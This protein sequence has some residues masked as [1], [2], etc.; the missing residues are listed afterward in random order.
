M[1]N[2]FSLTKSNLFWFLSL[3][4]IQIRNPFLKLYLFKF[5]ALLGLHCCAGFSLVVAL[6][7]G[8]CTSHCSGF[9]CCEAQALRHTAFIGCR[10]GSA[11]AA[12]GVS[13]S[14]WGM[15]DISGSGIK[16]MSPALAADF[17]YHWATRK[18]PIFKILMIWS[19]EMIL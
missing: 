4:I 17:F 6:A 13:G 15:W 8:T 19:V 10:R 7:C 11:V 3:C 9:S 12:P 1:L 18:A 5:L 16:P 2:F 14:V